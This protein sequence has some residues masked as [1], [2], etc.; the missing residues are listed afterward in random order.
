MTAQHC[1]CTAGLTSL[2]AELTNEGVSSIRLTKY[3]PLEALALAG[4]RKLGRPTSGAELSSC[5]L[6]AGLQV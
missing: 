5:G 2:P 1:Q 6:E 3:K 4:S